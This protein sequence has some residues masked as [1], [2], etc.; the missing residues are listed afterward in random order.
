MEEVAIPRFMTTKETCMI[1]FTVNILN[2]FSK[3]I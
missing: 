2:L 1:Y 3:L